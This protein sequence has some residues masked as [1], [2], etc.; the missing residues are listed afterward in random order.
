MLRGHNIRDVGALHRKYGDI[1]RIGPNE[2]SFAKTQAWTDIFSHRPGHTEFP[3][4][5]V[6]W[7]RPPGQPSSFITAND[8]DHAR[9]RKVLGYAFSDKATREMEPIMQK[10]VRQLITVLR[11][12]MNGNDD[13]VV[14]NIVDYYRYTTAC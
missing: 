10:Y 1:V 6:W 13:G 11:G 8:V 12:Q 14:V 9:M 4:N 7:S 3:R 2:L 5:P